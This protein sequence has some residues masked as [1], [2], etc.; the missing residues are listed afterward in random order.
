MNVEA[1]KFYS[2]ELLR[3]LN[4]FWYSDHI[5]HVY[6]EVIHHLTEILIPSCLSDLSNFFLNLELLKLLSHLCLLVFPVVI[7]HDCLLKFHSKCIK[8]DLVNTFQK[9]I[10]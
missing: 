8:S 4:V 6:I 7:S 10:K 9:P 5:L 1:I 3:H 2:V